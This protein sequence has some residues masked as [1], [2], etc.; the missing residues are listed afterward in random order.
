MEDRFKFVRV[1]LDVP[2]DASLL[3]EPVEKERGEASKAP[4]NRGQRVRYIVWVRDLFQLNGSLSLFVNVL[5]VQ[6]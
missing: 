1:D 3:V 6:R 2:V 5:V 4:S